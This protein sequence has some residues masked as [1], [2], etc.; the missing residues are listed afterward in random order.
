MYYTDNSILPENMAPLI[1]TAAPYGP[2][3]LPGDASD[4][5]LTWDEQVQ[6]AVDCYEAGATML[7]FHVRNPA[8]GMGSTNFER[9]Q[10]P[11][12]A[13][14]GSRAGHDHPG[15]RLDLV[16]TAHRRRQ[17]QVARLR[18][19][20]HAH[21]TG[22]EAGIRDRHDRH[23]AV[24]HRLDVLTGGHQ[25][26][27]HGRSRRCWRLGPAWWWI[28]RLPS[29]SSTSSVSARTASSLTSCPRMSTNG[30]LIERLIRA[31]STW[32]R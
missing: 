12:E 26:H 2:A 30:R 19:P 17:G 23:D 9:L 13:G 32:V 21:G 3:W 27:A 4:I 18:H 7:H 5:P 25:G 14:E 1:I 10:L 24:G 20:P 16:L 6:A 28:P 22:P 11:A 29:M 8:T 31:A 15:R